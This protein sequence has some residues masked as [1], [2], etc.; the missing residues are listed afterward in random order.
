MR[1]FACLLVVALLF[2]VTENR[3]WAV[4]TEREPLI[5]NVDNSH[6]ALTRQA[7]EMD[8][9]H[10][11]AFVDQYAGG[12]VTHLFLNT[13]AQRASFRS[14]TREA[15][16][17][18]VPGVAEETLHENWKKNRNWAHHWKI[19]H[20]QGIDPYEVMIRRCRRKNISP[21]ISMRMNDIHNINEPQH[22]YHSEFW[23]S[24]PQFRIDPQYT[25]NDWGPYALDYAHP[26]VR[27]YQMAFIEE[28]LERYDADGIE[29]DWLRF[30]NHL[31]N[32]KE[33]A[34]F[35]DD[36]VAEVRQR[37]DDWSRKRG[38]K[39]QVAVRVPSHP[40][41]SDSVGLKAVHWAKQGW[42]DII[43]AATFF[44]TTDFDVR[45]DLW[46]ERL[47]EDAAKRILLIG[48]ADC[49]TSAYPGAKHV[50]MDIPTLY[51]FADNMHYR[52]ADGIYLFNWF[53]RD[54][55]RVPMSDSVYREMLDGG[56]EEET[57]R[58]KE[59]RYLVG[60]LN[61]GVPNGIQ[62]P[63]ETGQPVTIQILMGTTP[64]E[65]GTASLVLAFEKRDGLETA[66]FSASLNGKDLGSSVE[67]KSLEKLGGSPA[68]AIRFSCPLDSLRSGENEMLL[69]QTAGEKQRLVWS[70]LRVI[71]STRAEEV[72]RQSGESPHVN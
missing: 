4:A 68:R 19:L 21:W 48:G 1:T 54:P 56:L 20:D 65:S 24:N 30:T 61:V 10:L 50:L 64:G 22:Y 23:R 6:F 7:E 35:I 55:H 2:Y 41:A 8:V 25:G 15:V 12:K 38:R 31:K 34:C 47:G 40:D 63:Q 69:R 51:G 27:Q 43:I 53:D 16:W 57:T 62:H 67:E 17:D 5:I 44:G 14:K 9:A 72:Y 29:L 60:F 42:I 11:E 36:F 70:E 66:T 59:R 32:K 3:S 45:F 39:I 26:E 58:K 46:R 18:P 71:P 28:L 33:D 13:N 52:G 49:M 37:V